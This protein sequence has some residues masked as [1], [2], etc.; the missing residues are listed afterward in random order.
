MTCCWWCLA[1]WLSQD[2]DP[3]VEELAERQQRA[4]HAN[5]TDM[6]RSSYQVRVAAGCLIRGDRAYELVL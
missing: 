4:K 6:V 5:V 2:A 1:S 3:L